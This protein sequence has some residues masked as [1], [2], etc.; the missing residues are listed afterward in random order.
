MDLYPEFIGSYVNL[1]LIYSEIDSL[2]QSEYYFNEGMKIDSKDPL[3]LNN[4]GFLYYKMKDHQKALKD[5]NESINIYPSN[6]YAY[7]NRALTYLDLGLKDEACKDLSIAQ[8]YDFKV[9]YGDEV[10]KLVEENCEK[11]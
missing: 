6:A 7:R 10:E 3:L 1:G 2:E 9:R 5:I 4:R 8:H 11:D